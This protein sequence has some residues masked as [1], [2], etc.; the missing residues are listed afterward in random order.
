MDVIMHTSTS[1]R[2]NTPITVVVVAFSSKYFLTFSM[3][4][5]ELGVLLIVVLGGAWVVLEKGEN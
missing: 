3:P 5:L 4:I 1:R 2:I